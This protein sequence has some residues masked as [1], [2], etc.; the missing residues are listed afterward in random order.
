MISIKGVE[1]N[2]RIDNNVLM[3]YASSKGIGIQKLF[4]SLQDPTPDM[5]SGLVVFAAAA[6]G[7]KINMQDVRD[8]IAARLDFVGELVLHYSEQLSPNVPEEEQ[9][10]K[11]VVKTAK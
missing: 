1:Y 8:E 4:S 3:D 10:K 2:P 6:Q 9:T 11:K 7:L 5:L